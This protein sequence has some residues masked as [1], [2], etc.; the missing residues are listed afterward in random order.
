MIPNFKKFISNNYFGVF[1]SYLILPLML[2]IGCE[3]YDE[4][5]N[6]PP[7]INSLSVPE[8][9][10]FGK[11]VEFKVSTFDAEED[12][13]TYLWYVSHGSLDDETNS[14]VKWKAPVLTS[15]EIVPPITVTVQVSVRDEGEDDISKSASILVYSKIYETTK[16]L[17]GE[18]ELVR[19]LVNGKTMEQTGGTMRLTE[20]TFTQEFAEGNK[21]YSGAYELIAPFNNYKGTINWLFDGETD[22]SISSYTWDGKF[23]VIFS[24]ESNTSHVY[25]KKQ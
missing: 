3:Q 23:L 10:E 4:L 24:P 15:D 8:R 16:M 13:L 5:R 19:T 14:I 20:S 7:K 9:V 1:I 2:L 25:E 12:A 18:Y 17:S 22:P 11:T 6:S 21:F